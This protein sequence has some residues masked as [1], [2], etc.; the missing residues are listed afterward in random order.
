MTLPGGKLW[1]D[2]YT[3]DQYC[4]FMLDFA[5]NAAASSTT[6]ETVT[7][8]NPAATVLAD[9][10]PTKIGNPSHP[11]LRNYGEQND[12]ATRPR[13]PKVERL[14]QPPLPKT[15]KRRRRSAAVALSC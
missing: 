4:P 7:G 9:D 8:D 5:D 15:M 13:G 10:Q 1:I 11:P 3:V 6:R 12:A 14:N 2:A